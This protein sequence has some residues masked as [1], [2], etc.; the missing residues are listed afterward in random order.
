MLMAQLIRHST[1]SNPYFR[2][3]VQDVKSWAL[4]LVF[5]NSLC[6]AG[7]GKAWT[8]IE[9]A[10]NVYLSLLYQVLEAERNNEEMCEIKILC[11]YEFPKLT[12]FVVKTK[13][14]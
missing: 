14:L 8:N 1:C 10:I 9:G 3:E 11:I 12:L 5:K 7:T 6:L 4:D 2:S 13:Y